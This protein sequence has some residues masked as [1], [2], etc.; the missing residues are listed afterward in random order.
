MLE[1]K[2]IKQQSFCKT[3]L[4]LWLRV[5]GADGADHRTRAVIAEKLQ[6]AGRVRRGRA[7]GN[8]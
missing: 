5:V 7:A 6:A 3:R 8:R 4:N 2:K 1:K